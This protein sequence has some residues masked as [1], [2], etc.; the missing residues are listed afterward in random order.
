MQPIVKNT[1]LGI[2]LFF[3]GGLAIAQEEYKDTIR[4]YIEKGEFQ[5]AMQAI[6]SAEDQVGKKNEW[7]DLHRGFVMVQLEQYDAAAKYYK[8]LIKRYDDNP[9]PYNNLGVIYRLQRNFEQAIETFNQGIE[10]FPDYPRLHENLG[11]T[12]MQL[13]Q[14]SYTNG[15]ETEIPSTVLEIKNNLALNF[16]QV[17]LDNLSIISSKEQVAQKNTTTASGNDNSTKQEI[18]NTLQAWVDAWSEKN[19]DA[20]LSY[21]SREFVP[22]DGSDV[23]SWANNQTVTMRSAEFIDISL[24]GINIE[25]VT[26][27]FAVASFLQHYESNILKRENRK[28]LS[29]RRYDEGWLIT[30]ERGLQ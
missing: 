4:E 27:S 8:K 9:E 14:E 19:P 30:D 21:Y 23:R 15:V 6:D 26:P 13:A 28:Q 11:D 5:Q 12:Y 3:T 25:V 16:H 10:K 29:F 20:Y 24:E 7:L 18:I 2:A 22:A 1:L 17:V